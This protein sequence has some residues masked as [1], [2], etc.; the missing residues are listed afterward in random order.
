MIGG[1]CHFTPPGSGLPPPLTPAHPGQCSFPGHHYRDNARHLRRAGFLDRMAI[2]AFGTS[3]CRPSAR[4]ALRL[5]AR[6]DQTG[7]GC[8]RP[9]SQQRQRDV[10]RTCEAASRP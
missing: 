10:L 5:G 2:H 4:W 6:L 1:R 7:A 3:A 8:K 9:V